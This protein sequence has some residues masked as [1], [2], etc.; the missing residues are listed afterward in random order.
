MSR[1][2]SLR[3]V[4]TSARGET[5]LRELDWGAETVLVVGNETHGLSHAYRALCDAVATIPMQG[6]ATSLNAAVATSIALY[7]MSTRQ[8]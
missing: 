4:G 3:V 8:R 5:P 1:C 6:T 7:E 2:Q